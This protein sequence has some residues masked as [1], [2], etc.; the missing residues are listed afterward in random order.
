MALS[1]KIEDV[2]REAIIALYCTPTVAEVLRL[3]GGSAMRLFDDITSR[4]SIDA[5][6]SAAT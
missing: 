4:L 5:D 1:M 2:I 6:F 3:K